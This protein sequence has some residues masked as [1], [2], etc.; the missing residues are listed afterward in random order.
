ML[1]LQ[2]Q[3]LK[4]VLEPYIRLLASH[5]GSQFGIRLDEE[6]LVERLNAIITASESPEPFEHHRALTNVPFP[7][8]DRERTEGPPVYS[9]ITL[10]DTSR[11]NGGMEERFRKGLMGIPDVRMMTDTSTRLHYPASRGLERKIIQ[12]IQSLDSEAI[13]RLTIKPI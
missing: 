3:S 12:T 13:N 10:K 8:M 1:P 4:P 7:D 9:D 6:H 11:Q 5:S 2:Y